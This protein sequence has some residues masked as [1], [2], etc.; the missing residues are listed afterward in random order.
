M[1]KKNPAHGVYP[2]L[3]QNLGAGIT[4]KRGSVVKLATWKKKSR[5]LVVFGV[6]S[7]HVDGDAESAV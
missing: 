7:F 2:Y 6:W 4:S 1:T 5:P 3:C